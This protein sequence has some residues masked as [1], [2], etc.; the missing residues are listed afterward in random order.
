M[1]NILMHLSLKYSGD[2]LTMYDSLQKRESIKSDDLIKSIN[3]VDCDYTTLIEENYCNN[4]KSIYKPPFGLYSYGKYNL[5]NGNSITIFA[6]SA[7]E[8]N[9]QYLE[10]LRNNKCGLLW[11]N[12]TNKELVAIISKYPTGNIFWY[13]EI[14]N[15]DNRSYRNIIKDD[16]VINS[17]VFISE[18]WEKDKTHDYSHQYDERIFLG[19]SHQCLILDKPKAK[20]WQG[21]LEYCM[22]ENI[23]I[24]ILRS[25]INDVVLKDLKHCNF[26]VIDNPQMVKFEKIEA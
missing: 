1:K 26:T 8:E 11:P 20:Q 19:V 3:K 5:V 4:L 9:N 17:N 25:L 15:E 23:K 2:W 14:R 21:L 12:P 10:Y 6:N 13:P 22:N 24:F 7:K 16:T 18:L